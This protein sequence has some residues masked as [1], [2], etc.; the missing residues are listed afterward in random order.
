MTGG[1]FGPRM[2]D[3]GPN[4]DSRLRLLRHPSLRRQAAPT[5]YNIT[6]SHPFITTHSYSRTLTIH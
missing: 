2:E 1:F 5:L 4:L 6:N 3:A